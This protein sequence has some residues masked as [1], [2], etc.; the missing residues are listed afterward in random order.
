MRHSKLR[1]DYLVALAFCCLGCLLIGSS[2]VYPIYVASSSLTLPTYGGQYYSEV[3]PYSGNVSVT[4]TEFVVSPEP[5]IY[6]DL[7]I[8]IKKFYTNNSSVTLIFST[9]THNETVPNFYNQTA[10]PI[11]HE[12]FAWN[13]DFSIII[14]Y[15]GTPAN[16][17]FWLLVNGTPPL[18][19]APP[20][21]SFLPIDFIFFLSGI[22]FLLFGLRRY[23]WEKLF[24]QTRSLR[25]ALIFCSLGILSLSLSY[26]S[27]TRP[28]YFLYYHPQEYTDFGEFSGIVSQSFPRVNRTLLGVED[29]TI[30]LRTF[31]VNHSSVTV[32]A[33]TLDGSINETWNYVNI[34]YPGYQTF[35]WDTTNDTVI[36][37]IRETG[38]VEFRSWILVRRIDSEFVLNYAGAYA[39]YAILFFGIG[40]ILLITGYY[41]ASQGLRTL[42]KMTNNQ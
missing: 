8:E 11:N 33:Y 34:Q 31:F 17:S 26:P 24:I 12:F 10:E 42:S 5:D 35:V 28:H 22:L 15:N 16:F 13:Y 41:H 2:I 25:R 36:E 1:H 19:P 21:T 40:T 9:N 4:T 39:P 32:R 7:L 27:L 29:S 30:E 18:I 23:R 37:V 20:D 6:W 38:D 14:Q 3:T